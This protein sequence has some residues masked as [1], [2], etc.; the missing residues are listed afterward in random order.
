MLTLQT[1]VPPRRFRLTD[2]HESQLAA[3]FVAD[4][5]SDCKRALL[6][7]ADDV[8]RTANELALRVLI[9]QRHWTQETLRKRVRELCDHE[10]L[11][12]TCGSRP[13][14]WTGRA[15]RCFHKVSVDRAAE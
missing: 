13:C 9:H 5:L 14:R 4:R 11:L 1:P 8:P 10:G 2:P 6:E 15:A 3:E 12:A 7:V